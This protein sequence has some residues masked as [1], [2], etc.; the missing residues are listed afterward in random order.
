M[1]RFAIAL[2]FILV[3]GCASQA[4]WEK[5]DR[6][7]Q[8]EAY[9]KLGMGYLNQG[10]V[11]RGLLNFQKALKVRSSYSE[12]LHGTAL[13][14]QQQG[15]FDLSEKYFKKALQTKGNETAVRNN[16]AAFLFNQSRYDDAR[17]QLEIASKDIYYSDRI[18]IFA[19]L[20]Y[21]LVK[22]EQTNK[23]IGYFQQALVLDSTFIPSHRALLELRS[24]QQEWQQAEQHWFVLRDAKINDEATLKQALIVVQNTRNQKELRYINSLLSDSK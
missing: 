10:Q 11:S 13:A 7:Q 3:S 15:E 8:A 9:T 12:A 24:K 21:V 5:V 17:K 16:Y 2:L 22:L 23:A 20:G 18:S 4:P 6:D 19:N 14:L 1:Q